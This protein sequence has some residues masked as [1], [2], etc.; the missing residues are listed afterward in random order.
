MRKMR[1]MTTRSSKL[2]LTLFLVHFRIF[3][4]NACVLLFELLG[5]II[6]VNVNF[7]NLQHLIK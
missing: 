3:Y 1:T 4:G 5:C 6:R 7:F 2:I